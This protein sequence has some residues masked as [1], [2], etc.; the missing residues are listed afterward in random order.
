ME[1]KIPTMPKW[2][3]RV[4]VITCGVF[5]KNVSSWKLVKRCHSF[6]SKNVFNLCVLVQNRLQTTCLGSR[7]IWHIAHWL[8]NE[9]CARFLPDTDQYLLLSSLNYQNPFDS[10][11]VHAKVS[12]L[13]HSSFSN[14][15]RSWKFL[16]RKISLKASCSLIVIFRQTAWRLRQ[17]LFIWLDTPFQF[18]YIFR[19][20]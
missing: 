3:T 5:H 12:S 19:W 4:M 7:G 11:S 18:F 15:C 10:W 14:N 20:R 6:F 9:Q 16:W 8:A 13:S 1:M 2:S 17:F